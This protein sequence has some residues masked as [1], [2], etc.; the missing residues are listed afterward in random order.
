MKN[1]EPDDRRLPPGPRRQR[2][3]NAWR[4]THDF[5]GFL[6]A[7]HR[8]FGDIVYFEL[9]ATKCCAVFSSELA[10]EVLSVQEPVFPP[11]YPSSNYGLLRYRFLQTSHGEE[12]RRRREI[13]IGGY[14]EERTAAHAEL[15]IANLH[16]L[17]ARCPPN[18]TIDLLEQLER[19]SWCCLL[20]LVLGSEPKLD[21]DLGRDVLAAMKQDLLLGLVPFKSIIVKLPLPFNRRVRRTLAAMDEVTYP[22][23]RRA[24]DPAHHGNDLLSHLVRAADRD[25]AF[26]L[27][28]SD[29]EIRDEA[30]G[31][32]C[33]A[34]D[35]PVG[36]L[37]WGVHCVARHRSVR[38]RLEQEIDAVLGD[39]KVEAADIHRLPYLRAVFKE[40]LRF[41]PPAY[42]MP[43]R[44]ALEDTV[45]AGYAIP[46]GTM[47]IVGVH[48]LQR[49]PEHWEDPDRFKP[50]RWLNGRQ[51]ADGMCP[52]RGYM[53][54]GVEP[55]GCRGAGFA[56]MLFMF[57]MASLLQHRRLEPV[58]RAAPSRTNL[59]IGVQG[60]FRVRVEARRR[61][62]TES[63]C[64]MTAARTPPRSPD[65]DEDREA[66]TVL[67]AKADR[68]IDADA[69]TVFGIVGDGGRHGDA[70]PE[71]ASVEF[72]TD[73]TRGLGTRFRETRH[74]KGFQAFIARLAGMTS[75]LIK[76]TDL[77]A[78]ERVR[79]TS[80]AGGTLWH[81]V[82]TLTPVDE[83][84]T[85][86]RV[87]L[88]TQPYTRLG[89]FG[90]PLMRKRLLA[91]TAN[92]LDAIKAYCEGRRLD[93]Q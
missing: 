38:N 43:A 44:E 36:A 1:I 70:V 9:P 73:T 80:D 35:A 42:A 90:P 89:R 29:E 54:F 27:Y 17:L 28:Q 65:K 16:E 23:I 77:V 52:E 34:I 26:G 11:F 47:T 86:L 76:C 49:C 57:A 4:R 64:L 67:I 40:L 84:R 88:E 21:P 15:I 37:T 2:L 58:S 8:R 68:V 48:V 24:R 10:E 79:Y 32:L 50:E 85:R 78:N 83:G 46:R 93:D 60:T 91:G 39:R 92:D 18:R 63:P 51:P 72:E 22:A 5:A 41:E 75:I 3:R 62:G 12:H 55:R 81:T 66:Q 74:L 19:F 14:A 25:R 20:D 33:A 69:E 56:A 45:L 82:Y 71:V 87:R 59:G 53:P 7:L 30:Y 31:H 6:A 13:M 61:G